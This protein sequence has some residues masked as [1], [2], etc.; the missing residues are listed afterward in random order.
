MALAPGRPNRFGAEPAVPRKDTAPPGDTGSR[1]SASDV[2]S[3]TDGKAGGGEAKKTSRSAATKSSPAAETEGAQVRKSVEWVSDV[4]LRFQDACDEWYMQNRARKHRLRRRP[5]DNAM[6]TALIQVGIAAIEADG[7]F[8]DQ[9][10]QYL[11]ID[12]R[13]R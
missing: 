10:E 8:N 7:D 11:P 13:R 4:E 1:G 9:L 5:S 2:K 12:G 3:A 6:I